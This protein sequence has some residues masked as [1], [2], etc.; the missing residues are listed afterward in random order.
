M[1]WGAFNGFANLSGN[2][3]RAIFS[4]NGKQIQ[5]YI[6]K[7]LSGYIEIVNNSN[8]DSVNEN[9]SEYSQNSQSQVLNQF[10]Q[11]FVEGK[12]KLTINQFSSILPI[13]D[14]TFFYN[15]AKAKFGMN[16]KDSE[17]LFNSIK[18]N[19]DSPLLFN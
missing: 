4:E 13:K 16:K 10:F 3:T 1:F 18:R 14:K 2:F 9:E 11:K 7:Y 8:F 19:L 12:Y 17:K 6:D 15:E 5:D